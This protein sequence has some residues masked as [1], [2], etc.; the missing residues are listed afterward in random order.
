[1][2]PLRLRLGKAVRPVRRPSLA[3]GRGVGLKPVG[4][5]TI[6][7]PG[8][9]PIA[10]P[11][12]AISYE[13]DF[14]GGALPEFKVGPIAAPAVADQPASLA[15]PT[16]ERYPFDLW[17]AGP[18][19]GRTGHDGNGR[20]GGEEVPTNRAALRQLW[21]LL[22]LPYLASNGSRDSALDGLAEYQREAV[23]AFLER[24]ALLLADDPGTGKT[25]SICVA[26]AGLVQDRRARRALLLTPRGRQL[27]WLRHFEEW[28]PGLYIG[29]IN[30]PRAEAG[31]LWSE[32]F[33]VLMCD[34]ARA[35]EELHRWR[36]SREGGYDIVI[37]DSLLSAMHRTPQ[38][39]QA[40]S[41]V[42]SP[43]RWA[44]A[45]GT[46]ARTEDWRALL[47]FLLP[48]EPIGHDASSIELQEMAASSLLRRTKLSLADSLPARGRR[49]LWLEL[50]GPQLDAYQAA[51]AEERHMLAQ[52]GESV[53][54]THID[55]ALGELNR[56]TAFAQG[57]LDG[58][59]VR[60]LTDLMEAIN[61][62]GDKAV[63]FSQYRHRSIEPLLQALHAYGALLLPE[64]ANEAERA[65][66]LAT[67][68][69]DYK[70]RILLAHL[71]AR[72]DGERLPASHIIHFDIDW[73][74]ARRIR[75]EQ[76]FFPQLKPDVPLTITEFWVAGTHDAG[77]HDLLAEKGV[78]PSDL[79]Q[80]TQPAEL[81]DR[82]T[83]DEWLTRVIGVDSERR[84][85]ARP[86]GTTTGLLPGTTMLR[87]T[88]TGLTES[89]LIQAVGAL[90]EALG[91]AE[92]ERT[93]PGPEE[94]V[95]L[96]AK[97]VGSQDRV[98]VWVLRTDGNVGVADG[99]ALLAA[100]EA[101]GAEQA[102]YLVTTG[103]F[104]SA[105]KKLAEE[106]EGKL[107]LV[108]GTEFYRHLRI[109]GWF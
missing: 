88:L 20:V 94:G 14:G 59:K 79:P 39:V 102:A 44:L 12:Q 49:E 108:A 48:D 62:A 63:L 9:L 105:C 19:I 61:A 38:G 37:A 77:L 58:V 83:I 53:T 1:V 109:L 97:A 103:D 36:S 27:H 74:S 50:D 95:A 67:F 21:A 18:I 23:Q 30:G 8:S 96:T 91:F 3:A 10:K 34:Y 76:R 41:T 93:G 4:I 57:S 81:E 5:T 29:R 32:P 17:Q 25:A 100:L 64:T 46:P 99:R 31:R 75:A 40:L 65:S 60:A 72:S 92:P 89:E 56:A 22:D 66:I 104:T 101:R 11:A 54:R 86:A 87:S 6:P 98:L 68:R 71:D 82:L 42:K 43:R 52:L 26:L 7:D 80:G 24:P 55:S 107:A 85:A 15:A 73:N 28:A 90:V 45:G 47:H 16:V 2:S 35:A 106:S 70:R 78:L 69:R 51:L 13:L 33:H 84:V